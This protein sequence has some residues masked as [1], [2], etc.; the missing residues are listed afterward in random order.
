MGHS[1]KNGAVSKVIKE[2]ISHPTRTQHT[3]SAA[4]TVQVSHSLPAVRFSCLLQG[5]GTSL[6]DGVAAGEG[7]CVLRFEMF[8]SVITVQ[9]EFRARFK[10]DIIL[11]RCV[12]YTY[13]WSLKGKDLLGG[14]E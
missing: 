2:S 12:L 8:R 4:G 5:R 7:F 10:K 6:Q 13:I 14:S 9:R 1:Q 11:V 3:L